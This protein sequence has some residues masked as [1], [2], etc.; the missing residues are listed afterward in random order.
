[1]TKRA[2]MSAILTA[3]AGCLAGLAADD[4]PKFEAADVHVSAKSASQMD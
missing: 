3:Y 4:S 2:I 1:M